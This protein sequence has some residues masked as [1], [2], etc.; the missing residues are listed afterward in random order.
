LITI[1]LVATLAAAFYM[2][3]AMGGNDAANSMGTSVGARIL[4]LRRAII[5]LALFAILGAV[6][7]G[8]HVMKTVGKGIVLFE[9]ENAAWAEA[10]NF[11]IPAGVEPTPF[12]FT[13]WAA[14]AS[15]F[16]A[17]VWVMV[18]TRLGLPVSTS[19]SIVGGVMGAGFALMFL[20]APAFAAAGVTISFTKFSHIALSWVL[21]PF[22]AIAFAYLAYR[23]S[24]RLLRRV[25]NIALLNTIYSIMV[26]ATASY[27]AY[28]FGANDVGNAAGA[29]LAANPT[30]SM[31]MIALFAGVAIVCGAITYSRRVIDTIGK[32]ITILAPAT[33]FAAL[34]GAA[35][36]VHIFTQFGIPVST[37]HAAVGGV[38]G[39]GLV[40][41]V[42]AVSGR[43]V[44]WISLAWVITPLVA[45]AISFGLVVLLVGM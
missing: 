31:Q 18:A 8:H 41:G 28:S 37:S 15:V 42:S 22:G 34:F 44:G 29:V 39:A 35:L 24:S 38:I 19:H 11:G 45:M 4:T 40:G 20:N 32:R 23:I 27:V 2:G 26:V 36:T 25:K 14:F 9:N 1:V 5:I 6:L 21:T 3:W 17:A 12:A 7:E 16:A 33:A 30:F 10:D 43:K 13:P